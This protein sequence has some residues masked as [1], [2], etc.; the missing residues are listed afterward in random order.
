VLHVSVALTVYPVHWNALG[1][2]RD[3]EVGKF[4]Q[5]ACKLFADSNRAVSIP[6]LE[7]IDLHVSPDFI[8]Y[9]FPEQL[10]AGEVVEA[11]L[12]VSVAL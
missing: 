6:W 5:N 11:P 1:I 9:V 7:D 3:P 10:G 12:D 8:E 2:Q 4:A